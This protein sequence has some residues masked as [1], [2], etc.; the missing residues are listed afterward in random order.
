MVLRYP[1][2]CDTPRRR[3]EYAYRA[4]ELL[5]L[6]HNTMGKWYREGLTESQWDR[7]PQKIKN[8]YPY[9]ARLNQAEWD[10]FTANVFQ[11]ISNRITERLLENRELLKQST[12]W[13]I[14]IEDV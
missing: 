4:Q 13:Q 11:P 8:R 12:A 5:R 2:D 1:A 9:K 10:D 14:D 7:F 3:T 6:L